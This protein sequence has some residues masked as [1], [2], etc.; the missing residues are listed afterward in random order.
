MNWDDMRFFL[1][2]AREGSASG[3]GRQLG[4]KHTT[5]VRRIR[6]FEER[7]GCRLFDRL[8]DG[9]AMTQAAENMFEQALGMETL[10]QAADRK[11][12][13]QD[14]ELAGPL[15]LTVGH[16]LFERLIL[17]KLRGFAAAYPHIDLQILTTTGLVDLA[18]READI[19]VRL[20]PKPPDY[21]V[22]REVMRLRHGIYGTTRTLRIRSD[23]VNV[24]LFRSDADH[25]PWVTENFPNARTVLRVDD[26]SSM[27]AATRN[28]LGLSKMPCYIGDSDA[29]LRRLDV[30]L[31]LS[32]WG[33]WILSHVDLRATARVRV[34]REFLID[35]IEQ[36]RP[37]IQGEKSRYASAL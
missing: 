26:V 8:P 17:P 13:G 36:Q 14:A 4:V 16:D 32:D 7:L 34:C 31:K 5:V 23:P 28:H 21:L 9:Y 29:A 10:A 2:V 11:V 3:A 6:A 30:P 12:F 35:V 33:V 27:A 15:K 1:A 22:G 37:L 20:T 24:I 25:P 18:A 19:A